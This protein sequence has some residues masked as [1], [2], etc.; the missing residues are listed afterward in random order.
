MGMRYISTDNTGW[1][2]V[3][4]EPAGRVV[5]LPQY[6]KVAFDERR[7]GRDYFNIEDGVYKGNSASV[8]QKSES[9]SW[10]GKPL[11]A[12][13]GPAN[14]VFKKGEGMLVTS[15]GLLAAT[16]DSNNPITNG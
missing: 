4:L 8:S 2:R 14:L 7:N 16:T 15:I 10:L 5:P 12:Y 11:L 9:S 13:K 6:I 1:L 3:K